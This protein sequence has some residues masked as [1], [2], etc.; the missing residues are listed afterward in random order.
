MRLPKRWTLAIAALGCTALLAGAPVAG[1]AGAGPNTAA[2]SEAGPGSGQG[3][4]PGQGSSSGA[5]AGPFVDIGGYGWAAAGIRAMQLEGWMNGAGPG[6][7]APAA[8]MTR[9]QAA[10]VFGRALGWPTTGTVTW[11][12][13]PQFAD[14]GAVP[15]WA[16]TYMARA[17]DLHLMLGVG[18]NRLGPNDP[19]TWPQLATITARVMQLA[20]VAS[21]QVPGLLAQIQNGPLTPAWASQAVAQLVQARV[22]LGPLAQQYSPNGP[23]TRAAMA[24]F[25]FQLQAA[26]PG[27][28]PAFSNRTAISG[29]VTAVAVAEP[30]SPASIT[31]GTDATNETY[32]VSADVTVLID[33]VEAT[34]ADVHVGDSVV[35][36]I[37]GGVNR[38]VLISVT[39]TT[40]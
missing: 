30:G 28:V 24:Q 1:A 3:A 4:G 20:P 33:G 14:A 8:D 26:N 15:D 27:T 11:P 13:G 19:L 5:V 17:C 35:V 2:G 40:A 29:V 25:M 23:V 34:L 36:L 32:Q 22:I 31:V 7:F 6:V 16:L 21:D 12:A 10:V 37:G 39:S 9:A 38:V 18:P